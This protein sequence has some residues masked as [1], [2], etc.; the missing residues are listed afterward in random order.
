MNEKCE[1]KYNVRAEDITCANVSEVIHRLCHEYLSNGNN[2][3]ILYYRGDDADERYRSVNHVIQDDVLEEMRSRYG[4]DWLNRAGFYNME[5]VRGF[6]GHMI[7]LVFK[8]YMQRQ[9][10]AEQFEQRINRA[11]KQQLEQNM[12]RM[13]QMYSSSYLRCGMQYL[14]A[15]NAGDGMPVIPPQGNSFMGTPPTP[16]FMGAWPNTP[17]MC[18][19]TSPPFMGRQPIPSL[20]G[21]QPIPPFMGGQQTPPFMGGQ[22]TSPFMGGQQTPPFMGV[23]QTPPFM[24]GQQTPPFMG[25]QQTPPFMGGQQTPPFMGAQPIPVFIY[26]PLIPSYMGAATNHPF[27]GGQF[28]L[29]FQPSVRICHDHHLPDCPQCLDEPAQQPLDPQWRMP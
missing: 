25:G 10:E 8:E 2:A 1:Q 6:V 26:A 29:I 9:E 17:F 13:S 27:M 23:Q 11:F 4:P 12:R 16:P 24:G 28:N 20:M 7:T 3:S 18:G 15:M 5:H 22:Q 21:G 14:H 19:Q